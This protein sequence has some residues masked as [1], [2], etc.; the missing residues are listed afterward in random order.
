MFQQVFFEISGVCNA[1]CPFCVTG[2][3]KSPAGGFI[4]FELFTRAIE[5]LLDKELIG[6]ESCICLYNWGEPFLHRDLGK[7][8]EYLSRRRVRFSLST[9]ASVYRELSPAMIAGLEELSFSL[10]GFSQRSYDRIHGFDFSAIKNNL[11][12][13]VS[14]LQKL[15]YRGRKKLFFH[16]YQFNLDEIAPARAFARELGV[17]FCPYYAFIADY[18]RARAY[19]E[20]R[21]SYRELR[22]LAEN[23][24]L[25]DMAD[26]IARA[27]AAY[28]CPQYD[29]LV[30]DEEAEILTCCY[31]SKGH[32]DYSCGSLF[33]DDL[34]ARLARREEQPECR[35]C[36]ES[37]LSYL[38]HHSATPEFCRVA[39][40]A[41]DGVH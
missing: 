32:P 36:R 28:R 13:F 20:E 35:F 30:L 37:G 15:G 16:I 1:R 10:P 7:I 8:L 31:L 29:I 2:A 19:L 21:L 25:A 17:E 41:K 18:N 33:D 9:N 38:V 24:F 34:Q 22:E 39:G 4:P 14:H 27:P 6:A 5:R 23:L 3:G 12:G 26:K 11:E 40:Q